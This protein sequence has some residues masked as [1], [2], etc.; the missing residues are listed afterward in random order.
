MSDNKTEWVISL[1]TIDTIIAHFQKF[2]TSTEK[3][4]KYDNT[5][6]DE[7]GLHT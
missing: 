6:K 1:E 5:Y 7:W 4:N 2:I 3:R